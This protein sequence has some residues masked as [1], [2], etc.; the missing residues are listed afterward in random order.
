MLCETEWLTRG[1][2]LWL[3]DEFSPRLLA[4]ELTAIMAACRS[5]WWRTR[6]VPGR[7]RTPLHL[8]VVVLPE[9]VKIPWENDASEEPRH[10]VS[11][12]PAHGGMLVEA[13]IWRGRGGGLDGLGCGWLW[14]G[15]LRADVSESPRDAQRPSGRVTSLPDVGRPRAGGAEGRGR[16][17]R[18]RCDDAWRLRGSCTIRRL[19][20]PPLRCPGRAN[21]SGRWPDGE[22]SAR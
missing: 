22:A 12:R 11:V 4:I 9:R 5:E 21:S 10:N 18:V 16:R 19:A 15:I 2:N 14:L 6:W 7:H 8:I 17:P 20:G 1:R 13:A 3:R